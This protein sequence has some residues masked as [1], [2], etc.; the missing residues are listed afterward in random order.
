MSATIAGTTAAR[1]RGQLINKENKNRGVLERGNNSQHHE[2][3]EGQS[4]SSKAEE[5]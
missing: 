4:R 2:V 3:E 5:G 1:I